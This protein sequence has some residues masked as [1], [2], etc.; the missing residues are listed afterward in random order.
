MEVPLQVR[1]P[2]DLHKEDIGRAKL[3]ERGELSLSSQINFNS[4]LSLFVIVFNLNL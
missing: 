4:S 2:G 3:G 1:T